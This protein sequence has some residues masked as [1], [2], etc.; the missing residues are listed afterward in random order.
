MKYSF[1]TI[2]QIRMK[3]IIRYGLI[4]LLL[5]Q[6]SFTNA[7]ALKIREKCPDVELTHIINYPLTKT[8]LS[9]FDGK[10]IILDFWGTGCTGCI[11][12]FIP[13]GKLQKEFADKLQI[14]MVNKESEDS[15]LRFFSLHPHIKLPEGIPFVTEDSMLA[16]YFPHVLYPH[17]VWIDKNQ[18]VRF[19]T[20]DYNT[21]F[22]HI[23]DFL[24]G[25]PIQLAEKNDSYKYADYKPLIA[26][27]DSAE[28]SKVYY[29][30][31]LMPSFHGY[32]MAGSME[33]VNGSKNI[34]RITLNTVSLFTMYSIAYGENGKYDFRPR[35]SVIL[36]V[37]DTSIFL[38]PKDDN[39]LDQFTANHTYA[40]DLMVPPSLANRLY[41]FMQQDLVRYFGY[42]GKVEKRKVKCLVL[43][44]TG[45]RDQLRT[46]GGKTMTNFFSKTPDS[47]RYF[48]NEP[49]A[50]FSDY[51]KG[52]YE[53]WDVPTPFIDATGYKRNIDIYLSAS[54]LNNI[55]NIPNLNKALKKYGLE[56]KR[57]DWLTN[58]LVIQKVR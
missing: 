42:I 5:M 15:T 54:T 25:I 17:D 40:Y 48:L 31:Y 21:T 29:Y 20:F 57:E 10:L 6:Y 26:T 38:W 32:N 37:P 50:D 23:H 13:F 47:I 39:L 27:V 4:V 24:H 58:V 49:F 36:D 7:Q 33:R 51:L 30:S 18:N 53:N 35:N 2:K 11:A 34:N 22:K 28:L 56:I 3:N 55:L 16:S 19:I 8:R 45:E 52:V 1:K 44:R 43:V 12:D 46:K 9:N 41:K 14:I